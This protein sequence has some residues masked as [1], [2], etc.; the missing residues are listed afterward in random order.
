MDQLK[1]K[2]LSVA[3]FIIRLQSENEK[4]I[5]IQESYLPFEIY[6]K[7]IIS[8]VVI[9]S[10]SSI[11]AELLVKSD[12]LFEAKNDEQTFFSI[13]NYGA[14]YKFIIYD[15]QTAGQIQQVAILDKD[16]YQ[17]DV[18]SNSKNNNEEIF[19]L[20][21]PFG[22]LVFYYLTVKS[23][24]IMMH[25]SAVFD[26]EKGRLF[27]GFSGAGKSTM[28][29]LW[30]KSGAKIIN[31]DRIIIRKE[32]GKFMMFNTPM[33]YIDI[34]KKAPLN[35]IH[36]INHANENSME[37]IGGATA[38]S[39]LMAFCIQHNFNSSFIDHNLTFISELCSNTPVYETG[40]L[41]E[42]PIVDLIKNNE[43]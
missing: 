37:K 35:S 29:Y 22:P 31:D 25:A 13:Y 26:G 6:G 8:D 20:I 42:A 10:Y 4:M 23:D 19:P 38:V 28:A 18:Y 3:G 14:S 11:P 40:F 32:N 30:Q 9:T 1:I 21:Y 16:L 15:Q 41:P 34:S 2:Y 43:P 5:V 33:M 17:W 36:L 24:G 39:R 27:T 12:L 7:A